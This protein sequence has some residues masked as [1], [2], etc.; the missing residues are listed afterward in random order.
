MLSDLAIETDFVLLPTASF[1]FDQI[2]FFKTTGQ[3][4]TQIN[5]SHPWLKGI[6]VVY[7]NEVQRERRN[8]ANLLKLSRT[9][10]YNLP[11]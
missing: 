9:T 11:C 7:S 2:F 4:S 5:K 10:E 1:P 6:H 8:K 3:N